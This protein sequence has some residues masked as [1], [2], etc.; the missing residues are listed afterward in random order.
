MGPPI[1]VG[2]PSKEHSWRSTVHRPISPT[3]FHMRRP[4][5]LLVLVAAPLGAQSFP[6]PMRPDVSGNSV[7]LSSDH[8][9]ATQA[10]AEVLRRGGNAIDAAV[11]MA[12]VLNV[13]RP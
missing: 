11:T 6:I 2:R 7:A 10:G 3:G 9:P 12:G 13:V 8:P 1:D 5:S 4:L